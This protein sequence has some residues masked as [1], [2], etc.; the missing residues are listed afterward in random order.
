ML[1][2]L[3][4]CNTL[5]HS[6][7]RTHACVRIVFSKLPNEWPH[8]LGIPI[9][10][11]VLIWLPVLGLIASTLR[12]AATLQAILNKSVILVYRMTRV[13]LLST[14]TICGVKAGSKTTRFLRKINPENTTIDNRS[15]ES[16]TSINCRN[17]VRGVYKRKCRL[18]NNSSNCCMLAKDITKFL[19]SCAWSVSRNKEI[20][21]GRISTIIPHLFIV[22]FSCDTP[23]QRHCFA[24]NCLAPLQSPAFSPCWISRPPYRSVDSYGAATKQCT[25]KSL[26]CPQR[27]I[28]IARVNKCK[29]SLHHNLINLHIR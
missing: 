12:E 1:T 22:N 10:T 7:N 27:S 25:I 29:S 16:F 24:S 19:L 17:L 11:S 4:A 6:T 15:N 20:F 2:S 9:I 5:T 3:R 18:H 26:P 28:S 8:A 13:T 21:S 14:W 23:W